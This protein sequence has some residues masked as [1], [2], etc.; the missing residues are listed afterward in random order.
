MFSYLQ[1]PGTLDVLGLVP[2]LYEDVGVLTDH[3]HQWDHKNDQEDSSEV[4]LLQAHGP[5]TEVAG[6]FLP[7]SMLFAFVHLGDLENK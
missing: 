3:D 4:S 6:A 2:E 7:N 5:P 1:Q